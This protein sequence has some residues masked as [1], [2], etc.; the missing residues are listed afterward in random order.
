LVNE[1]IRQV[2]NLRRAQTQTIQTPKSQ[3]R[4]SRRV[5]WIECFKGKL[6]LK[7]LAKFETAERGV[8][9]TVWGDDFTRDKTCDGIG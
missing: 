4:H 8:V 1:E 7:E 3:T 9:G 5:T 6:L 2:G